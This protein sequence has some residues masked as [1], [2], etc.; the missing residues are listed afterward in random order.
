MKDLIKE[1]ESRLGRELNKLEETLITQWIQTGYSVEYI[2]DSL[3]RN[4]V[5]LTDITTILKSKK[6]QSV[7][8]HN[9]KSE[10]L[11]SFLNTR[12]FEEDDNSHPEVS[13]TKIE[14][15]NEALK[16]FFDSFTN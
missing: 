2:K 1:L 15:K 11:L 13:R 3:P 14:T 4:I 7:H 6:I 12:S 8:L 10:A 9:V 5:S 16:S